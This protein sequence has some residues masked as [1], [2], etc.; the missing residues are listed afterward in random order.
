LTF[1]AVLLKVGN[2]EDEA[3][4]Y[5]AVAVACDG[6]RG[7][8]AR[9]FA[10]HGNWKH[11][12]Q[13]LA[14]SRL[15]IPGTLPDPKEEWEALEARSV[16]LVMRGAE[17][18][19]P[20]LREIPGPPFAIYVKGP[21]APLRAPI[22]FAIVGT[23]R[24][25]PDGRSIAKRFAHE[26]AS[27][28][29]MI[30][31]G[32]AFGVDGAAH[33]GC[34]EARG[35]TVAVLAGGLAD[36]YPHSHKRLAEKILSEGGAV[37]SE[38]P[39]R[40]PPYP[41]RFLE[42]NRLVSGLARGTLIVEAPHGSGSL[43]TARHAMEA[44]RDVFVV[45]GPI[46]HGNYKGSHELIRQGAELVAAPDEILAAYGV[47]REEKM[48]RAAR[49]ATREETLILKALHDAHEATDVD[50]IISMTKLEP[51]VVNRSLSFLLLK[52]L[53]GEKEYGYTI[54][55]PWNSSS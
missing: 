48:A 13:D 19:P 1:A 27:A 16:R 43:I 52:G 46:A 45:P 53:V 3:L 9:F 39:L 15:P 31:S 4:Y 35:T 11:A 30:V 17:D 49:A 44:N 51:R 12:W 50:K 36:V 5:N 28:G 18:F 8:V 42:R 47:T 55:M 41:L 20:L 14:A 2:M 10:A 29:M 54:N 37:I 24:V 26:L 40:A 25:T 38:Y 21:L 7:K 23:R 32:L 6:D 34:L 33:E 22:P